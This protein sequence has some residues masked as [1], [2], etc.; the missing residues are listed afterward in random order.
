M[1]RRQPVDAEPTA[2]PNLIEIAQRHT[3]RDVRRAAMIWL[4]LT[5]DPRAISLFETVLTTR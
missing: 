3:S 2:V 1:D 4:G 5:G